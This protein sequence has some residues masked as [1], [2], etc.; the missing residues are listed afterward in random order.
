MARDDFMDL[1][2]DTSFDQVILTQNKVVICL[3]DQ[4]EHDP[5]ESLT[6]VQRIVVAARLR[7]WADHVERIPA[8]PA[9]PF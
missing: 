3:M 4:S 2:V 7:A 1:S 6:P 9:P 5:T 8:P